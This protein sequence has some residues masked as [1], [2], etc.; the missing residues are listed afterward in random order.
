MAVPKDSSPA[1]HTFLLLTPSATAITYDELTA[2]CLD[3][4]LYENPYPAPTVPV[5]TT[6]RTRRRRESLCLHVAGETEYCVFTIT[7]GDEVYEGV[8]CDLFDM[9]FNVATGD[10]QIVYYTAPRYFGDLGK[11]NHGF[12][13]LLMRI[14]RL[15]HARLLLHSKLTCFR[16][17]VISRVN[18]W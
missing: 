17:L 10:G 7:I 18:Q 9:T 11:M 5:A 14:S 3:A 6:P 16:A 2:L 12:V 4:G 8:A 13:A 1:W 15:W